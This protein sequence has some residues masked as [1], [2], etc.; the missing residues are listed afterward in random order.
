MIKAYSSKVGEGPY[1]T[2]QDNPIGDLIRELGHEYGA[3][4][5]RP[6]R[7][8]WLD[9]PALQY[10]IEING[11]TALVVNHLDTIG[12]LEKFKVCV[13]YD[14]DGQEVDFDIS[15]I[16]DSNVKPVYEEFEGN[17]GDISN[18]RKREELPLN[19]RKYIEFIEEYTGIP[20]KF[21]GV[22]PEREQMIIE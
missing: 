22:G 14:F 4:T 6:R 5:K 18:C 1:P 17:F 19:A 16:G 13:G 21:I 3:T 10:A 9:L 20:V 15:K 2:E 7:C 8:G 12:K 11:I